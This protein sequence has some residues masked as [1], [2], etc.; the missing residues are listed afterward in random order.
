MFVKI[1]KYMKNK[2]ISLLQRIFGFENYLFIFSLFMYYKLRW[3][4][5]EKD[6]LKLFDIIHDDGIVLDIGANIGVMT[7][8]FAKRLKY[9]EI[10]SFEPI[11]C[12]IKTLKRIVKF[13]K[14]KNVNL[15]ECALSNF[16][17]E[18]DMIL[19]IIDTA[20]KQGLSH[21]VKD[22]NI[23]NEE[24][25]IFKVPCK[26]LDNV[27]EL[28]NSIKRITA[29]KIDVE[30]H[31]LSVL[32]GAVKLINKNSPIIYCEL[33]PGKQR[34]EIF[35]FMGSLNYTPKVIEHNNLTDFYNQQTQNFFFI[36]T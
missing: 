12:N 21:V 10:Y 15:Y 6:F 18:I 34:K 23:I 11:P 30:G 4:K 2:I 1:Q 31:E 8:H 17:G 3:D 26:Q 36:P 29:I 24:G 16:E 9:S 13:F 7:A 22:I 5:N 27:D 35:D 20:K 25:E 28:S 32:K 19:P 33:W 14:L